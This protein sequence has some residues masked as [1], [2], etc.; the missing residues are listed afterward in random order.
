MKKHLLF[1]VFLFAAFLMNA[2]EQ[3]TVIYYPDLNLEENVN[4]GVTFQDIV[5]PAGLE[6]KMW[7]ETKNAPPLENELGY[8][9]VGNQLAWRI[10]GYDSDAY[11]ECESWMVINAVD[12]SGFDNP[13]VTFF[14]NAMYALG[15]EDS[16]WLSNLDVMISTDYVDDVKT[17]TWVRQ[18]EKL[19]TIDQRLFYDDFG[20]VKST[21]S[22]GDYAGNTSV[23]LAFKYHVDQA[24]AI[25]KADAET[26][27]VGERPGG[28]TVAEVRF[29]GASKTSS[30]T[31]DL[32]ENSFSLYPNPAGNRI[33]FAPV[34]E[35][36]SIYNIA[37]KKVL[38]STN[39][40]NSLDISVL[41]NGLYFVKMANRNNEI[42]IE[43]LIK[44]Y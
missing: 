1:V 41:P 44:K 7:W 6:D 38:E 19:D 33:N 15:E 14:T 35:I 29:T 5:R 22:L 31:N 28:W 24:G 4:A 30:V 25:K 40:Q 32:S 3:E 43:K 2:Q 36:V 8:P 9:R 21:L 27:V 18:N 11:Y 17:A 34:P 42:Q 12:L 10:R 23:T 13:K 39:I 16:K 37:G 26:G 20:W